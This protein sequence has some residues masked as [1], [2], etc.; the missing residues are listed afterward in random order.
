MNK[1]E[2]ENF[3][4]RYDKYKNNNLP[5]PF[6]DD[7]R[8]TLE[9]VY[10]YDNFIGKDGINSN[11]AVDYSLTE[12]LGK[13]AVAGFYYSF[14]SKILKTSFEGEKRIEKEI[15]GHNHAHSFEDVVRDLY[16]YP[17]SFNILEEDKEFYS[18]QEL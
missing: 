18:K 6:W 15:V 17:E 11:T 3:K 14:Q 10:K 8:F 2:L 9:Y 12:A 13:I 7:E 5:T 4:K 1:K 16:R